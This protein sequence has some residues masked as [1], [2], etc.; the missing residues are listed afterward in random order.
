MCLP[1]GWKKLEV[2]DRQKVVSIPILKSQSQFNPNH[3][4]LSLPKLLLS[5]VNQWMKRRALKK[6][7]L[8]DGSRVLQGTADPE[9][10]AEFTVRNV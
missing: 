4:W 1:L 5:I 2:V 7:I 8:T 9:R 3:Q 10:L 6:Q